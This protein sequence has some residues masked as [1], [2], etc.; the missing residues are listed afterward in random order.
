VAD[1]VAVT[2]AVDV[3]NL[4]VPDDLRCFF[5]DGL[6]GAAVVNGVVRLT[7]FAVKPPPASDADSNATAVCQLITPIQG[8]QNIYGILQDIMKGLERDGLLENTKRGKVGVE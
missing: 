1:G 6:G 8:L 2:K 7:L 5:V 3:A 4:T